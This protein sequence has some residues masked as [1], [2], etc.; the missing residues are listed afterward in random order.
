[1]RTIKTSGKPDSRC[2]GSRKANQ[3]TVMNTQKTLIIEQGEN[4]YRY[5]TEPFLLSAFVRLENA[6]RVLDIGTGCGVIP[7]LLL[8]RQP[9]MNILAIEIQ[10]SLYETAIKNV[11]FNGLC[12]KIDVHCGD[13]VGLASGLDKETFDL[14]VSN[15]PYRKINTGRLNP[16]S[17]KAIARHE[18]TL[19]LS[20]LIENGFPLL[21][22]GGNMVLAYPPH[23][24]D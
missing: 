14:I 10:Y 17:A 16:D 21:K 23:P 12:D 8:K 20:A 11:A 7:L 24:F 9:A 5:S 15:P 1:M 6:F 18:L 3:F 19:N 13:F 4:G 2:Y 22:A